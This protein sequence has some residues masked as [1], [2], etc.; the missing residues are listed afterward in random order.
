MS[1]GARVGTVLAEQ[2]SKPV[3]AVQAGIK[4]GGKGK[5]GEERKSINLVYIGQG[6]ASGSFGVFRVVLYVSFRR[7][8]AASLA[9]S[10]QELADPAPSPQSRHE[11]KQ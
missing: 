4:R 1:I 10:R 2:Q 11:I 3:L 6:Y 7:A 8:G 5:K 9:F